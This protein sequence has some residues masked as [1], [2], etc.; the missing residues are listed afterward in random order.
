MSLEFEKY[1]QRSL[2]VS[3]GYSVLELLGVISIVSIVIGGAVLHFD[4]LL[5]SFRRHDGIQQIEFALR[6]ARVESIASGALGV[7]SP[8]LN[9]DAYRF[10]VDIAPFGDTATADSMFFSKE[11]PHKITIEPTDDLVF[12][13]RGYLV[14]SSSGA[15]TS[16]VLSLK[17]EGIS[18]CTIAINSMGTFIKSCS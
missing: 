3:V 8:T 14:N 16:S 1:F 12:D 17:Y 9:G 7:F 18:Y 10:G 11:L 2:K 5:A 6:R 4:E 13:S 15:L